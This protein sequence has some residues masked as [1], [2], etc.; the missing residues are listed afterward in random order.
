MSK[1]A[2]IIRRKLVAA[3]APQSVVVRD[4]SHLHIGHAETSVGRARAGGESHF[5]LHIVSAA[6]I[7]QSRLHRQRQVFAVLADEMDT[8]IHA[9]A[10]K[11][12]TPA[13]AEKAKNRP[14]NN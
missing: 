11:L 3:F 8:Q 10:V 5:R 12:L 7:G 9:L 4:E 6:F 1:Y 13:E 14:K 2:D